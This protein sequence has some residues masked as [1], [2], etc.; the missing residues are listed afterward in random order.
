MTQE[1]ASAARKIVA[2]QLLRAGAALT[3]AA[4][5]LAFA[6]ADHLGAGLGIGSTWDGAR[7]GQA[8]VMLFFIISGYVMV[9]AARGRFGTPGARGEFWRRRF[10]RIMPPYW[11]AT[12]LL[13]GV[14]VVIFRRPVDAGQV[15]RSLALVPEWPTD[16]RLRPLL[17]LWVGWTLI[18]E[19]AFYFV[20]GL[21]L[22]LPRGRA[23]MAVSGVL[24]LVIAAGT[25]VPPADP[26]LF[27]VTRPLPVMFV[28][29][30]GLALWRGQGGAVP[31]WLRWA[32]LAALVPAVLVVGEPAEYT[33]SDWHYLL[34]AGLP[35]LLI[36][37]GVLGGPL[38]LPR[39]EWI[40]RAGDASYALY[41]LHLP[42][43]WFWLWFWG[44]LP[45]FDPGPWDY[46]ASA[47]A[48]SIAAS[49]LFHTR[50]ERPMLLALNRR[51]AAPHSGE[52][53][54]RKTP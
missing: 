21:F 11:I 17:F 49:W 33:A 10:I 48:A 39:P 52:E 6:F 9:E 20:F 2:I 31:V 46:L 25:R 22:P 37:G 50:I 15:A 14:L 1:P 38:S 23:I 44:R 12:L 42:V 30:M 16:G 3:V 41:L 13:A 54:H 27:A 7:E 40:N 45:F 47:L 34:W 32:M 53:L 36:A 51:F 18:Y 28:A 4:V 19:M 35:A 8:A 43:A 24:A 5:H 29:G 26:L